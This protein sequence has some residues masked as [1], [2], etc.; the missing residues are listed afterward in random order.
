MVGLVHSCKNLYTVQNIVKCDKIQ[1]FIK[2]IKYDEY[3]EL[4]RMKYYLAVS[5]EQRIAYSYYSPGLHLF[6][7]VV[8]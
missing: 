5:G 4:L 8:I 1:Y 7:N 2:I 3:L 6:V